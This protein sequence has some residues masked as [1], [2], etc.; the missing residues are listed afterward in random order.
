MLNKDKKCVQDKGALKPQ[1]S[2][3]TGAGGPSWSAGEGRDAYRGQR[4]LLVSGRGQGCLQGPED[5]PGQRERAGVLTGA[6]RASWS[7]VEGRDGRGPQTRTPQ[8]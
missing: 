3:L 4:T 7:V 5:P 1:G 8:E 6:G 2:E